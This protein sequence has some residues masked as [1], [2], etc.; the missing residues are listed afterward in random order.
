[1]VQFVSSV[2]QRKGKFGLSAFG[3]AYLAFI[4]LENSKATP[5]SRIF[6]PE[7]VGPLKIFFLFYNKCIGEWNAVNKL[8]YYQQCNFYI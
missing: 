1:V 3:L 7:F 4:S 8:C 2:L 5:S 6:D